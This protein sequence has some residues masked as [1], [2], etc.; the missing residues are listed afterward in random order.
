MKTTNKLVFPVRLLLVLAIGCALPPQARAKITEGLA[1]S[2]N[3]E[4]ATL[5]DYE[6]SKTALTEQYAAAMPEFFQQENSASLLEKAAMDKL[7][8]EALLRQKADALKVKVYERELENG[9]TEIRKRFA[10]SPDGTQLPPDKAEEAFR[11]ELKK[12][13][14]TMEEFRE[15]IRKQLMVQKLVQDTVKARVK[16]PGDA[17]V[18]AYFDNIALMLK[19]SE[20]EVKGLDAEALEE[21]KA[22]TARFREITAERLRLRHILL[23]VKEGASAEEAAAAIKKAQDISQK[24]TGDLDFDD[25]AVQYSEDQ[26]SAKNGGDLGYVVK[27]MLPADIEKAAFALQ[28]GE[29]SQPL[30][31]K[32][33][34]HILRLEEKRAP[35][36]L[37]FDSVKN[38][39]EQMLSQSSFAA[40]LA[41]YLKEL[42]KAAK[43]QVFIDTKT[44]K[45]AN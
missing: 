13:G 9:L 3:T 39:L 26:E 27:G 5:S 25:A 21:L 38:D 31:S 8:D 37:R 19:G 17:E 10:A 15:K 40:E 22:V 30:Q 6:R 24:L 4:P 45:S 44:P 41:A 12:D 35:Q 42:R 34:W 11:A 14:T 18:K 32:F 7:I 1:A 28:V 20:A 23:K 29:N 36:K 2:V 33:G 43:V 16:L